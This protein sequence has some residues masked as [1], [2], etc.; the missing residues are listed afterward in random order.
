VLKFQEI[1]HDHGISAMIR[2]SKGADIHAAC[3]QLTY[4]RLKS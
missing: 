3:G 4:Q 1:L 2:K